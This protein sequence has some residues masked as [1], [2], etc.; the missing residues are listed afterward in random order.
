V[1]WRTVEYAVANLNALEQQIAELELK[2]RAFGFVSIGQLPRPRR[3]YIDQATSLA[4][5][6]VRF[7]KTF[8]SRSC[9]PVGGSS[10][11]HT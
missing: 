4:T 10:A 11:S 2:M 9:E 1:N 6:Q 5:M 7:M 3:K 8:K